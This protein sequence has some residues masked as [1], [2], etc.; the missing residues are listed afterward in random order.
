MNNAD[1]IAYAN[2]RLAE[3]PPVVATVGD[4]D[5]VLDTDVEDEDPEECDH[6]HVFASND[7]QTWYVCGDCGQEWSAEEYYADSEDTDAHW[8]RLKEEF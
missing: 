5:Y 3:N 7:A 1:L 8:Y 6:E 2:K 4:A